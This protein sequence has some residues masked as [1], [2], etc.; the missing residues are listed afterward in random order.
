MAGVPRLLPL[1][2]VAIGGVLAVNAL[3]GAPNL[4]GAAQSFAEGAV[5]AR[6]AAK[7]AS[8]VL[9]SLNVGPAPPAGAVPACAPS[10]ADLAKEAGLSPAEL[11]VLQSLGA[12]RGQLD[13][14]EQSLDTQVQLIAAA[15]AKLD[16]RIQQMNS[17]KAEIQALLGQADSQQQAETDRLVTVYEAMK[18]KDAAAR[19]TLM[20]D[21][22]RLPMAAKM[23]PRKLAD[24]L[25]QM[26]PEDAK[27]L[28]EKLAQ[29]LNGSQA[30]AAAQAT[31]TPQAASTQSAQNNA[32]PSGASAATAD[33][34]AAS[35]AADS[36]AA[37][38][39][40]H[41]RGKSR[42]HKAAVA[43]NGASAAGDTSV[44]PPAAKSG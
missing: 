36:S 4:V 19:M 22:V 34:S 25:A 39:G 26:P 33:N 43:K 41:T 10:A 44:N 37:P 14:R 17:L 11:Q 12:R 1:V 31:L 21:S 16:G 28:S 6:A 13:Q 15:E 3:R 29:R 32:P 42:A 23:K 38:A 18:P 27:N 24:I 40:K 5:S 35:S 8:S 30:V 2:A 9:P 20:D 7:P